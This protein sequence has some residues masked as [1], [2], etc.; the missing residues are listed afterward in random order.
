MSKKSVSDIMKPVVIFPNDQSTYMTSR[1]E[2]RNHPIILRAFGIDCDTVGHIEMGYND[3]CGGWFWG[4]YIPDCDQLALLGCANA[5]AIGLPG[6]YRI[7]FRDRITGAPSTGLDDLV[8]TITETDMPASMLAQ[9]S[10]GSAS[11]ACGSQVSIREEDG[12]FY[13][14]VDNQAYTICPGD[15]VSCDPNG[16]GIV[17]NGELCPFPAIPDVS[18]EV[19]EDGCLVIVVDGE[20]TVFC[21]SPDSVTIIDALADDIYQAT[22]PDGSVVQWNGAN[23][24]TLVDEFET[25][26]FRATN[27]DG[28]T[29]DWDGNNSV[30]VVSDLGEGQFQAENPD[31]SLVTWDGENS[32]TLAD[33]NTAEGTITITNPD[34][35]QI[36]F[37]Y[38]E[39][40]PPVSEQTQITRGTGGRPSMQTLTANHQG[41]YPNVSWRETWME[42][43][44]DIVT[45]HSW[46]PNDNEWDSVAVESPEGLV[47]L[48]NP[49]IYLRKDTGSANPPIETQA[50]LTVSNAF[51]SFNAVR[52]FMNR[53][54]VV[55][56]VTIDARGDFASDASASGM[57]VIASQAFKNAQTIVVRGDPSNVEAL[58]IPFGGV[59]QRG[60]GMTN[61]GTGLV[62]LEHMTFRCVNGALA[63][64]STGFE[65]VN[66]NGGQ[67]TLAGGIRLDG[68]YDTSREGALQINRYALRAAQGGEVLVT[69]NTELQMEFDPGTQLTALFVVRHQSS[70]G[71][72]GSVVFNILSGAEFSS[73]VVE[74]SSSALLR[75]TASIAWPDPLAVTGDGRHT[76]PYSYVVPPLAV[77]TAPAG[78]YG[79][80]AGLISH[81]FGADVTVGGSQAVASVDPLGVVNDVAGP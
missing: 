55:G 4:P 60:N 77:V 42:R 18:V 10:G 32:V 45:I 58:V 36:T 74:L 62:R 53:T 50:D 48:N 24:I 35:S 79:G 29:V 17:I 9:F 59:G 11:M 15:S 21:P 40:L 61:N 76:A 51:N 16:L 80:R 78:A 75:I 43:N 12:C 2:V 7:V 20:A 69:V 41:T 44:G 67:V 26:Q 37:L 14:S 72:N 3:G 23:S 38:L 8:V 6:W 27:P 68:F 30:T 5:I 34:G 39:E 70:L 66:A 33:A 22:N 81:D 1:F 54:L 46:N 73:A 52:S 13:I 49:V 56:T 31:G 28:S 63:S 71:F 25:G 57:G 64:E 47:V 65:A 19:N